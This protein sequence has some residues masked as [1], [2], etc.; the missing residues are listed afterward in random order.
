MRRVQKR[1]TKLENINIRLTHDVQ[2]AQLDVPR[3]VQFDTLAAWNCDD[4]RARVRG[5]IRECRPGR[6]RRQR[7]VGIAR[8]RMEVHHH[9]GGGLDGGEDEEGCEETHYWSPSIGK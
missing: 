7:Q 1:Y 3:D 2:S 8:Q 5:V 9:G 4:A 6:A